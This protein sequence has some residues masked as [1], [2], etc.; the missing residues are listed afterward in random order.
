MSVGSECTLNYDYVRQF[1]IKSRLSLSLSYEGLTLFGDHDDLNR[2]FKRKNS[3]WISSRDESI[4]ELP[5]LRRSNVR[6]NEHLAT[7]CKHYLPR[8][9]VFAQRIRG[10]RKRTTRINELNRQYQATTYGL[11]SVHRQ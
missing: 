6:R 2:E 11:V 3:E 8:L 1:S 7:R 10:H 4:S 5:P 9:D